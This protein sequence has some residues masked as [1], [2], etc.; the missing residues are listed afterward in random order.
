MSYNNNNNNR[1]CYYLASCN[2]LDMSV[3]RADS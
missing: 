2:E 1:K 3:G